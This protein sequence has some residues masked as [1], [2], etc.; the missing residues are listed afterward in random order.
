MKGQP[1][2]VPLLNCLSDICCG[3]YVIT[4]LI[5][6]G[7][8]QAAAKPGEC[9]CG[10]LNLPFDIGEMIWRRT[11]YYHLRLARKMYPAGYYKPPESRL[12]RVIP[13]K[14]RPKGKTDSTVPWGHTKSPLFKLPIEIRVMIYDLIF[15]GGCTGIHILLDSSSTSD[16]PEENRRNGYL[17]SIKC[18]CPTSNEKD[19]IGYPCLWDWR[20]GSRPSGL[21]GYDCYGSPMAD[22]GTGMM[23]LV[24]TCRFMYVVQSYFSV[25]LVSPSADSIA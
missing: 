21:S 4:Y 11:D 14:W 2:C 10:L 9:L 5:V 19:K 12:S 16:L 24:R 1:G 23:G 13:G 6:S 15:G 7:C 3:P 20:Q 8:I 18:R 22:F 25:C 17:T